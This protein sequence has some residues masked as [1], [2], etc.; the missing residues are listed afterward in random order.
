MLQLYRLS[1]AYASQRLFEQVS[2]KVSPGDRVGLTGPNGS[3]KT[4]L[5]R[6]IT[7]A[8][9]ADDGELSM[10]KNFT[11]GYLPQEGLVHHGRT[12]RDEA[13]MAFAHLLALRKEQQELEHKLAAASES[14]PGFMTPR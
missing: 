3:G 11:V 6:L 10:P 4:S 5:L 7:G 9:T 1:K 2:W 14:S 13:L 8:E 12:V